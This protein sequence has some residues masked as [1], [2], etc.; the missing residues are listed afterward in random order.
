MIRNNPQHKYYM[1]GCDGAR[2]LDIIIAEK[3]LG[4]INDP[5][6]TFDTHFNEVVKDVIDFPEC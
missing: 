4:I 6:L 5:N 3:D 2:K 1:N